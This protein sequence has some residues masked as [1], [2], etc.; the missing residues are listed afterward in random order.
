MLTLVLSDACFVN[1]CLLCLGRFGLFCF[2]SRTPVTWVC[3]CSCCF[4]SCGRLP[5]TPFLLSSRFSY[6]MRSSRVLVCSGCLSHVVQLL[7]P[8]FLLTPVCLCSCSRMSVVLI[9]FASL[10]SFA[11]NSCVPGSSS[12]AFPLVY[13]WLSLARESQAQSELCPSRIHVRL[14]EPFRKVLTRI[15]VLHNG[16]LRPPGLWCLS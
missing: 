3:V 10:L 1:F 4:V 7:C 16:L 8:G 11:L 13:S 2:M 12:G 14:A 5:C 9:C 15:Q 6:L